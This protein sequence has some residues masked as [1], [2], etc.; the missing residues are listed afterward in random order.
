MDLAAILEHHLE[1]E[2][3]E[4]CVEEEKSPQTRSSPTREQWTVLAEKLYGYC[5]VPV[6]GFEKK[7]IYALVK[8]LRTRPWM[9]DELCAALESKGEVE[10]ACVAFP[11]TRDGRMQIGKGKYIPSFIYSR[12]FRFNDLA[13]SE[14]L[15][16]N[17]CLHSDGKLGMFCVNP[18][19]YHKSQTTVPRRRVFLPLPKPK[20]E[21]HSETFESD[22]TSSDRTESIAQD[23]EKHST[24]ETCLDSRFDLE[25]LE[26][27]EYQEPHCRKFSTDASCY[28]DPAKLV[29]TPF[30]NPYFDVTSGVEAPCPSPLSELDPPKMSSWS[31]V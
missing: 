2:A 28:Y 23:E 27:R 29:G 14:L 6:T 19:H 3:A 7:A 30:L 17:E 26:P 31:E 10:T 16:N 11:R 9:I 21:P 13:R 12:I 18:F 24:E 22:G 20:E 8:R 1:P 4:Q 15:P 5:V 25:S